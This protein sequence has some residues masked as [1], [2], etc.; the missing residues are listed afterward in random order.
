MLLA[1]AAAAFDAPSCV[2]R[3]SQKPQEN[4]R[5]S[6]QRCD[7]LL[8]RRVARDEGAVQAGVPI[9]FIAMFGGT[10]CRRQR[11]VC[12]QCRGRTSRVLSR[13]LCFP[14]GV[15]QNSG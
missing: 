1:R 5:T 14:R 3:S 7:K 9:S 10:F 12:A 6:A 8:A 11:L 15:I 2:A 4:R 13:T